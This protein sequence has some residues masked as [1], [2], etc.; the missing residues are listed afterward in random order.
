[1]ASLWGH[2]T[3]RLAAIMICLSWLATRSW[4]A[5]FREV[6]FGFL[7]IDYLLVCGFALRWRQSRS[8]MSLQLMQIHALFPVIHFVGYFV[9]ISMFGQSDTWVQA[10]LRNRVFEFSLLYIIYNSW[11][12]R[13]FLN[14]PDEDEIDEDL[15]LEETDEIDFKPSAGLPALTE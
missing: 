8:L 13:S 11:V 9:D 5:L 2:Q 7:V 6:T 15:R 1:M 12:R 4:D 10:F 14:A 3:L